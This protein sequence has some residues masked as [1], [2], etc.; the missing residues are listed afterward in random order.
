MNRILRRLTFGSLG[1]ELRCATTV[2]HHAARRA[3][4]ISTSGAAV[5]AGF[6][7]RVTALT[8]LAAG[9]AAQQPAPSAFEVQLTNSLK[10]K[11]FFR[12]VSFEVD[13]RRA[14]FLFFL[15][16][17][18]NHDEKNHNRIVINPIQPFLVELL[19]QFDAVYCQPQ[20]IVMREDARQIAIAILASRGLYDDY[21]RAT[22]DPSLHTSLAHYN[23][24]LRLAVTYRAGLGSGD[25][26]EERQSLL[27][28][29]V[30]ALQHA[31]SSTGK[32]PKPMWFN[33]GLAEYRS[34]HG[35]L[36]PTLREPPLIEDHLAWID[37][38]RHNAEGRKLM[39]P[40]ADLVVAETYAQVVA[41]TQKHAG[42]VV[43]AQAA[44]GMFYAQSEM[45]V[46][47]L[48]EG[49]GGKYRDGF[50]RYFKA[51]EGGAGGLATFQ[52]AFGLAD[53]TAVQALD[54]ECGE[55]MDAAFAG[56]YGLPVAE[57]A[58]R[59][60]MP[61]PSTFDRALLTWRPEELG[62]RILGAWR[63]C[64]TGHFERALTLLPEKVEAA[65][66]QARLQREK[67]RIQALI[68]LRERVVGE[69]QK[70]G[71]VEIGGQRGKFVARDGADVVVK[72]KDGEVRV[73]L[74]PGVLLAQGKNMKPNPFEFGDSWKEILLRWLTGETLA[75]LQGKLAGQYSRVQSL[76]SDLTVDLGPDQGSES[77]L[78]EELQQVS[79]PE[80]R[81]DAEALLAK[82]LVG[83][84]R[85]GPLLQ[86]RR[87]AC[88]QLARALAE[89]T[90]ALDDAASLGVRGTITKLPDGRVQVAYDRV[91]AAPNCDFTVVPDAPYHFPEDGRLSYEGPTCIEPHGVAFGAIGNGF[92]RWAMPLTGAQ[93]VEFDFQ[94]PGENSV[95][96]LLLCAAAGREL[97]VLGDGRL[98]LNDNSR[99]IRD[100]NGSPRFVRIGEPVRLKVVH[101]GKKVAVFYN[102]TPSAQ[103]PGVG[104]CVDGEL[105]LGV[106]S[107]DHVL[108]RKLTITGKL[109]PA[110]PG[111]IRERFV[112]G[113]LARMWQA[114][115]KEAAK[116]GATDGKG[117]DEAGS[118]D[119]RPRSKL[120]PAAEAAVQSALSWLLRHQ[121]PEGR[122]DCDQFMKHDTG[123]DLCDGAGLDVHDVA[124]TA[125]A[126]TCLQ[127]DGSGLRG[128]PHRDAMQRGIKWL[129]GQQNL[130]T[131]AFGP[132]NHTRS[133]YDHALATLAVTE[134]GGLAQDGQ[135]LEAAQLAVNF[136]ESHRNPY[137]VWGYAPRGN[138]NTTAV[139]SFCVQACVAARDFKLQVN[140]EAMKLAA[141][142]F[143]QIS[144]PTGLHG[145]E[146]QG[147]RAA[148]YKGDHATRFPVDRVQ[149]LTAGGLFS[150]FL[151]G[152]DPKQKPVMNAAADLL[153]AC[154]PTWDRNGSIDECYFYFGSLALYQFGG[155]PWAAWRKKLVDCVSNAQRRD[156]NAAGSWDPVG[157]W[158]EDGGRVTATALTALSLLA[159]VRYGRLVR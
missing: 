129:I 116:A 100:R 52:S 20:G 157:P 95:L 10:A 67:E 90:F 27:H 33:E 42:I 70:R 69:L 147:E 36:P 11:S 88:E 142:W 108:I 2:S 58:K 154:P 143:D 6:G 110:N 63:W 114:P 117:K 111:P 60:A 131:G 149:T 74:E 144:D 59:V 23:H 121:D 16:S 135:L 57:Q 123:G 19:S 66:D 34:A 92:L 119:R 141:V 134:I 1:R 79:L 38:G 71:N 29:V 125:L 102:G 55:W 37:Y 39:L 32:M 8:L 150:R 138:Q 22:N 159:P 146:K 65:P 99:G 98:F 85:G 109:D 112:A 101:D 78:L 127:V 158:S 45:V 82:L 56:R 153:A 54:K 97:Q 40:L 94:L 81:A 104:A 5:L 13:S 145:Y 136:L 105:V 96:V 18:L 137:S 155:K 75:S 64:A 25:V 151:L 47:F 31:Y 93:E 122:W 14:P 113:V 148:R 48:H 156:G 46:R 61:P 87:A 9:L 26:R 30:H 124:A 83:T 118:F 132:M 89:R 49:S 103:L 130:A 4:A 35:V 133:I 126:L 140:P 43:P 28:E 21:A 44:L 128:G 77:L 91:D 80:N 51:V 120:E 115:A 62:A 3:C 17:S 86:Q 106:R 24:E 72:V 50:L 12:E 76:R 7:C 84:Q 15:Q 107:S 139:T 73:R 41:A 152:Q 53:L 68:E